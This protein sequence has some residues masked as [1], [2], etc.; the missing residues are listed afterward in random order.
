[1]NHEAAE[2]TEDGAVVV[3]VGE[4]HAPTWP[5]VAEQLDLRPDQSSSEK[6]GVEVADKEVDAW[7]PEEWQREPV[8]LRLRFESPSAVEDVREH[9]QECASEMFSGGMGEGEEV[10]DFRTE[11]LPPA[12]AL[13]DAPAGGEADG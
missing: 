3:E 2:R 11:A 4:A 7:G 9:L 10:E 8:A 5:T 1:M 13:R 6:W 12:A